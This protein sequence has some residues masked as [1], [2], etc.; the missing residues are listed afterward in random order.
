MNTLPVFVTV[1]LPGRTETARHS[2][3][4]HNQ[5]RMLHYCATH[6]AFLCVVGAVSKP[7]KPLRIM[8]NGA[9]GSLYGAAASFDEGLRSDTT[10]VDAPIRI[11]LFAI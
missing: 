1:P 4:K 9:R 7:K 10:T 11:V 6:P 8:H 3:E 2:N 5:K